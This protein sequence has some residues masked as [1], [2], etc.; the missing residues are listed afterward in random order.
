MQQSYAKVS[1]V[2]KICLLTVSSRPIAMNVLAFQRT[3]LCS[4][5]N[6][7]RYRWSG[8][9]H[10]VLQILINLCATRSMRSTN[11]NAPK[12]R[13]RSPSLLETSK[14]PHCVADN[15]SASQPKNLTRVFAHAYDQRRRSRFGL[16]SGAL[17]ARHGRLL[18]VA[19]A[20]VATRDFHARAPS[21][22]TIPRQNPGPFTLQP[23]NRRILVID[24]IRDSRRLSQDLSPADAKRAADWMLMKQR[25]RET[26]NRSRSWDFRSFAFQVG[27]IR[28][29][30][31]RHRRGHLRGCVCRCP[32]APGWTD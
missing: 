11:R 28:E 2:S 12:N 15:G 30:A 21:A 10:K 5:G 23:D 26:V 6:F 25:S 9:R 22:S 7:H 32:N 4:S 19:S 3:V 24:I 14:R 13:S 31:L 17:A 29:S 18:F 16:H 1:G 20:G 8:G 27:G